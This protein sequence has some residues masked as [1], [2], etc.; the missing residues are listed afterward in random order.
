MAA[1]V[2]FREKELMIR[3]RW[4][5]LVMLILSAAGCGSDDPVS[6]EDLIASLEDLRVE[7]ECLGPGS[8]EVNCY[9]PDV[10][11]ESTTIDG[12]E[13]TTY[14][15]T[16]R[17]RG[18]VEQKT[19]TGYDSSDGMW[20]EGGTPDG[21]SW[22]IFRLH[23]SSPDKTYYMN[24]GSSGFDE[25]WPLDMTRT[26]VMDDGAVLTLLADSGGDNLGT[27]NMDGYGDPIVIDGVSPYPYAFDGQFVQ[28]DIVDIKIH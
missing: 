4:M 12:D 9:V 19:Y 5:F 6:G 23:V 2:C 18:V 27:R 3:I 25:C 26:I 7:L 13:G 8:A 20:I 28:L 17:I 21:G 16:I 14:E 24:S 1:G 10:D 22:N 15:V 11:E